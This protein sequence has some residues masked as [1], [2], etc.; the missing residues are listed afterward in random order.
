MTDAGQTDREPR[1][2][3]LL[4]LIE[5]WRSKRGTR[6]FP[7]RADLDPL[8]L[9]FMLGRIA[10]T[11]VHEEPRRYRLRLV[12][13]WWAA[14]VGFES[15]GMWLEDWPNANQRKLTAETYETLIA[16]RRP[17]CAQRDAWVD[18][19]K[20]DYEILLLP[21]SDDDSRISMIVTGIGPG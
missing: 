12:G 1:H 19:Q 13:S 11:E 21:L 6:R 17:L 15:T 9:G 16:A 14:L 20:L 5:Y 7:S 10:L 8:D 2:P 3:D 4:R 18:D